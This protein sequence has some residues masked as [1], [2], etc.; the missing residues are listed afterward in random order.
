MS[1]KDKILTPEEQKT[2]DIARKKE[3]YDWI[4]C[5]ISGLIICI[6][7][8]VFGIRI[9]DVNGNSMF[10]SL[11]NGDRLLVS[12]VLYTPHRGDVVIFKTDSYNPNKALV[13]RII[14][15]EG[16]VINIDFENGIVYVND[17][18]INEPYINELTRNKLNF[19]GP[20]TVP[21]NC[22]FVMGDNRNASTDSRDNRIGMVD[23]RLIIGRAYIRL[24]PFADFG[25]VGK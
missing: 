19:I 17:E 13:K 21:E 9:I 7:V 25:K 5:I 11:K 1:N 2:A 15:V 4:Q 8:F 12:G 22:V 23:K 14:A 20:Q 3:N 18:A 6:I 24:F 10:P 16:D